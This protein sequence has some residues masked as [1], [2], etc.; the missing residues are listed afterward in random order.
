MI[1]CVPN[2][3]E[4]RKREVPARISAAMA[5]AGARILDWHLDADHNRSVL[6]CAGAPEVMAEAAVRGVACA[7]KL[8]DLRRHAG[9]HPR[10]GAAD[11]VPFVPLAGA[12]M[13]DCV[14][15]AHL[16]GRRI[17]EELG[18]PIYFYE[19]AALRP[20]RRNLA[21]VRRGGYELLRSTIST[22]ERA[23]D[24]GPA[25]L[26]TDAGA[27]IVGARQFLVAYNINL[28]TD[29]MRIAQRIARTIRARDGGLPGLKALGLYLASRRCAQ[30]SMNLTDYTQTGLHQ[31]YE[32]VRR[33][34]LQL[35][36]TIA[37]HEFV[38]L[39]PQAALDAGAEYFQ[40]MGI[41]VPDVSLEKRLSESDNSRYA[42]WGLARETG[43]SVK[44]R[45]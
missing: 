24:V 12:T 27:C 34:A 16:T 36:V 8:I 19:H 37:G 7:A 18:I 2:F 25:R 1:E 45:A 3:S 29:D 44:P 4:G 14:R 20:E 31:A 11:V 28:A 33:T 41:A 9:Q 6:T 21:D 30:V 39:V 40:Q 10:V 23:P 43:V 15:L 35:G 5:S 42:V 32:A 38:G 22:P 26:H 17:A 13:A